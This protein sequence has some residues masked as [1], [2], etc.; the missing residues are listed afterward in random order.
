[1]MWCVWS[2]PDRA[3]FRFSVSD[4]AEPVDEI[5]E[6]WNG[7]YLSAGE[8]T[9]RTLGFHI[10]QKEP[11]VTALPIHGPDSRRHRQYPTQ[12]RTGEA[13]AS[14]LDRYFIRPVGTF[15]HDSITR[16]FDDLTYG[17][18]WRMF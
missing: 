7:R 14:L 1:M 18:Y 16:D 9:W 6:Y 17:E 13:S 11:G 4:N 8:A 10:T 12:R 5:E 15:V 3:R 2:G